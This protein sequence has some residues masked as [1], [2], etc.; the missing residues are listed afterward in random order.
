MDRA[1]VI[2]HIGLA[3]L[4]ALPCSAQERLSG[5]D[6]FNRKSPMVALAW[7]VAGTL[8]PTAVGLATVT[9]GENKPTELSLLVTGIYVG[10][11]L[12][13]FYANRPGRAA[14]GVLLRTA[15]LGLSLLALTQ[16]GV[17]LESCA[18]GEQNDEVAVVL[19]G[20]ALTAA[21]A[22]F[23]IVTAPGSARQYNKARAMV[24]VAPWFSLSQQA[25][26]VG[27]IVAF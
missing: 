4:T 26:A 19:V 22:V 7:S 10:P 1:G 5:S 6:S 11:S 12:G 27:V 16:T 21:S 23:D 2:F 25:G 3:V 9:T 18:P 8:L 15:I 20:T 14:R 24:S 17:C 13:H